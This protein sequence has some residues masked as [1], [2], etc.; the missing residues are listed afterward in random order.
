MAET[1]TTPL[2][3]QFREVKAKHQEAIVFFRVGDF[4]EMF[5]EDAEEASQLLDIVLTSRGKNNDTPIPLC[6]VPY[7]AATG[8]IARLLKAGRT[9]ALCEQVEDPKATKGLVRREVVRLYTPGTLFDSDLLPAKEANILASISCLPPSAGDDATN[10]IQYGLATLDLSTGE[11]WIVEY[12]TPQQHVSL[13]DELVRLEPREI[14]LPSFAPPQMRES[15][16]ELRQSRLVHQDE[17]WFHA[18]NNQSLLTTHFHVQSVHELGLPTLT[19]G[20]EAAGSL[21]HYLQTTQ[22]GMHHQHIQRPRLRSAQR[23]MKLDGVTI[24]NL[25]LIKP[26]SHDRDSSTLLTILDKTITAMAGRLLRQWIVR[27]LIDVTD[28][29]ARLSVIDEFVSNIRVRS[30]LRTYLRDVQDLERVNSRIAL[31]VAMPRDVLGLQRS[32]NVLPDL[33]RL[34]DSLESPLAKE[35]R[36]HWDNLD[37]IK[38]IIEQ[39]INTDTPPTSG[40]EGIIQEGFHSELDEL[41]K[42]ARDGLRWIAELERREKARSGIETLK[43]KYNRVF[44][45]YIEVTKTHL[46]KIPDDYIRKQTLVNAERFTTDELTQLENRIMGADQ[47]IKNLE[48]SLFGQLRLHITQSTQRIQHIAGIIAQIDVFSGLAETAA[49]NRYVKPDVDQS[50]VISITEGRHPVIEQTEISGGFISN[51]THLDLDQQ[52]LLLI[53]GPNMAG[54]STYL[55]Q[56]ALIV[57]MAQIGSFVPATTARIGL[58]DRIFTRIGASDDLAAG[59]STFM[60][61]MAETSKILSAA[62]SKSL[63]LLDEV[64][65]GT[66]TYDGLSIAWAVAEYILD[67]CHVGARTLFATH[68][69]EMTEL[70]ETREGLKNYTVQIKEKNQDVLFLRKIIKGKAN[71]SYGIH[72]AKLAGLPETIIQRAENILRQLEQ[73]SSRSTYTTNEQQPLLDQT[74]PPAHV[75]LDEVKQMD[76]FAMTPLEALNRLAD[77]KHRLEQEEKE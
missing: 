63:I 55:R 1:D 26:F 51:D 76:L 10:A 24:R 48:T 65:R 39:T 2:M 52:R 43:I 9:V 66:S 12:E 47:K 3:R 49:Q 77:M 46:A 37:D 45:Y 23:E 13:L 59:Q 28:I 42:V 71:R 25:E 19:R 14:I 53:T 72:V 16:K 67:R 29:H 60:V 54:K 18:E 8:Y 50:S 40:Y 56:V 41:R 6:G 74:T 33:Q 36:S 44:G 57:L 69:H 73:E 35:L 21:L 70:E 32:L 20:I 62:T 75:I 5:F 58:V 61:E 17:S 38:T 22:P 64:G 7:H 27:P 11:Y 31:G 4:Y 30:E 15:L 34:L 68:Y